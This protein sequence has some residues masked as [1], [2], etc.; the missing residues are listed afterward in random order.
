MHLYSQQHSQHKADA[1]K[2]LDLDNG[3]EPR[4]EHESSSRVWWRGGELDRFDTPHHHCF[5]P[6]G[7]TSLSGRARHVEFF[8]SF[9]QSNLGCDR[10]GSKK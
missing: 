2:S 7:E 10:V 6:S 9:G 5:S 1:R 4:L 3:L 8:N